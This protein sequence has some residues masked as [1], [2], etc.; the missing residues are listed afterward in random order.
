MIPLHIDTVIPDTLDD[1]I[2]LDGYYK[3]CRGKPQTKFPECEGCPFFDKPRTREQP[4]LNEG[5]DVLIVGEKPSASDKY[6]GGDIPK[7]NDDPRKGG[8]E[9]GARTWYGLKNF[10]KRN[11][12]RDNNK[13]VKYGLTTAVMC[14]SDKHT[15]RDYPIEVIRKC[16]SVLLRKVRLSGAK[17][18][19]LMGRQAC[20]GSPV[21]ALKKITS[22]DYVRGKIYREEIAGRIIY[23]IPTHSV[24]DVN[25]MPDLWST[26]LHDLKKATMLVE[27]DFIK[28]P[29]D[30]LVQGYVYPKNYTEVKEVLS[31]LMDDPNQI[32][33][34][35]IETTGLNPR[36]EDASITV[37]S[38]AW[39]P[40]KAAAIYTHKASQ[41]SL[42]LIKEFLKGRTKKIAHNAQ[43][44][45]GYI[46][47]VWGVKVN[48]LYADTMLAQYMLDENRSGGEERKLKGEFTLKKLT[49][50]YLWDYGGYEEEGDISD[51]FKKGIWDQI[52]KTTLLKYAAIDADVTLQLFFKQL[53]ILYN[54]PLQAPKEKLIAAMKSDLNYKEKALHGLITNFMP[55][56]TY[57]VVNLKNTGMWVDQKYLNDLCDKIPAK[58]KIVEEYVQEQTGR[59]DLVLSKNADIS[60]TVY[61]YLNSDVT[62][63]TNSGKPSTAFATLTEIAKTDNTGIIDGI[64]TYKKLTK[65]NGT[66]LTGI[67][68]L[69]DPTTGR[70]HPTYNII[71]TVTGRLS[72]RDPNLQQLPAYIKLPDKTVIDVKKI[73][74]APPGKILLYSDYSQVEM[75]VVAAFATKFGDNSMKEAILNGLD[76]HSFVASKVFKIP[77]EEMYQ[78]AKVEEI[79]EYVEMRSRAKTV[80]FAIL[81]GSTAYG[82]SNKNN[83]P[84]GE[85]QG[86]IDM[87]YASF[88]G[89]ERY[90][91]STHSEAQQYGYVTSPFGRRRRFPIS[92]I[93]GKIDNSTKRKAQNSPV[94]STA[95]D[96][97]FRAVI[98]LTEEMPKI[99][100]RVVVTV[101]D[102]LVCEIPDN[103]DSIIKAHKIMDQVMLKEPNTKYKFLRGVPLKADQKIGYNWSEMISYEKW[104]AGESFE[105]VA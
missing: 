30:H 49:W 52:P 27:F 39:A 69:T 21:P 8:A 19:V 87:F 88:P 99:G 17:V 32:V 50:D 103:R 90:V 102:S 9:F 28:P 10:I 13:V 81:Y 47:V 59:D 63:K 16:G 7:P 76:L 23:F 65:L 66:F 26:V 98:G 79:F 34:F 92:E 44:D 86:L 70:V 68:K 22:I 60:W 56:A 41:K 72:C 1:L 80:G 55:R 61:D 4:V 82:V 33:S 93:R 96:I 24:K 11:T 62:V 57:S 40:G 94:Q 105:G 67:K 20:K 51:F 73:F 42:D 58:I 36:A 15:T 97:C 85:A 2:D 14:Y 3:A 25:R 101:H 6:S 48:A 95:S 46:E 91:K 53:R 71:G 64:I 12:V 37:L 84:I 89:I 35:D 18:V 31:P 100:G 104:F 29:I 38:L 75:G 54:L 77:Y 5:V 43:Y 45:V 74:A 83:I 78:K